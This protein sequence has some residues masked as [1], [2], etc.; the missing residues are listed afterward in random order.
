MSNTVNTSAMPPSMSST[1]SFTSPTG[2]QA[3]ATL[4]SRRR[5]VIALNVATYLVLAAFA[6]KLAAWNGWTLVDAVM[7]VCFLLGT[8]WA[9]LGFWN[10]LIGLWLL[11]GARDAIADVA[12]YA[13]AGDEAAPLTIRTAVLMTL[14]NEDPESALKRLATVKDSIDATGE[15][16][17]FTYFILSDTNKPDVAAAEEEGVARWRAETG[18]GERIVYRRRDHNKGFKA[19]NVRDFCERWSADYE[20]MLPLDADSLMSGDVIVQMARMMQAHPKLGILQSLV[21]GMPSTSAFA[22][23]FQFGMRHGMRSYTMGQAWWV[24]DCGP[25]WATTRSCASSRSTS[26]ATCRSCPAPRRSA[27]TCSPTTRSRPP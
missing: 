23:I 1:E 3:N 27:A 21:V 14:R 8:P 19:G 13:A 15:G 25:F 5:L 22:R 2:L 12:P 10:A 18:A 20:L 9:V 6:W 11:H 16:T 26:S 4:R 7:Y 24:G 17:A